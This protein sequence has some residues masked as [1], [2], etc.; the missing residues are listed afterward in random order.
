MCKYCD[1]SISDHCA[2][3]FACFNGDAGH[4]IDCKYR[5]WIDNRTRFY[6]ESD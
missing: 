3:C 2:N 6:G 5:V 1:E 4:S